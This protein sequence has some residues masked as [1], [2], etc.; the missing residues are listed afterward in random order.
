MKPDKKYINRF[1]NKF[2]INSESQCWVWVGARSPNGYGL[3]WTGTKLIGAHVFSWIVHNGIDVPRGMYICHECDNKRCVNPNHLYIGTPS[4][5][6]SD[7]ESRIQWKKNTN[8]LIKLNPDSVRE[9]RSL[10]NS[11]KCTSVELAKRFNVSR[12]HISRVANSTK[13]TSVS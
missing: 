3:F 10:Y 7:R 12:D 6:I 4:E 9:I 5:N 11:G 2:I 1:L 8:G 13:W